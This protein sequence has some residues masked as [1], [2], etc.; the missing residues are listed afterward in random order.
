MKKHLHL[1]LT[2]LLAM[3]VVG[4][5]SAQKNVMFISNAP[6]FPG[7]DGEDPNDTE[8]IEKLREFGYG[9]TVI[10][11]AQTGADPIPVEVN[12]AVD[13]CDV[14]VVSST[15]SSWAVAY[16]WPVR[17]NS[18]PFLTWESAL[19]DELQLSYDS[20]RGTNEFNVDSFLTIEPGANTALVGEYTGDVQVVSRIKGMP[21]WSGCKANGLAPGA[22]KVA[23]A[24]G[25]WGTD[26][27]D[28]KSVV[29]Y[30]LEEGDECIVTA[31]D[32]NTTSPR[33]SMAWWFEDATA[34]HTTDI[35]WELFA[36]VMAFMVGEAYTPGAV[37]SPSGVEGVSVSRFY[38]GFLHL[39]LKDINGT[40]QIK[41]FDITGKLVMQN[42]VQGGDRV[43]IPMMN[44]KDGVYIVMGD[45]FAEKFMKR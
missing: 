10:T 21:V 35:G 25:G 28:E 44:Y 31:E 36:R 13:S 29:I 45:D 12:N 8:Y 3:F 24:I 39:D 20:L 26:V 38:N 37:I 41:I 16:C 23:R 14:I 34:Y 1:V 42:I 33:L 5:L 19:W 30:Y 17:Y 7:P 43:S 18:K 11:T 32:A 15:I 40:T 22:H 6:D 27:N 2:L 9:V 4:S